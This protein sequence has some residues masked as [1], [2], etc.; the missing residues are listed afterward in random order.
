VLD[1]CAAPGGKTMQLAAAGAHVTAL[2]Q[3]QSR[4][5]RVAENLRRTRHSAELVVADAL[6]WRP[7]QRFD[8]VLLDAPCSATGTLRRHPDAAHL[9]SR[10]DI[11]SM[12]AVQTRLLD[13][14]AAAVSPG[15]VLVYCTCSLEPEEGSFQA[16][17]FSARHG[18]AFAAL[19]FRA[20]EAG[21]VPEWLDGSGH[22]R[23]LPSHL[24][25]L[26]E[27]MKGMDGF[28]AARWRRIGVTS[29]V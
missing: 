24:E 18:N 11:E 29:S 27:G 19:P 3:S 9:K 20:G 5:D 13:A 17:A 23:T 14:A 15:G 4:L 21:L 7:A 1:L 28:F 22:L 2:D 8:A 6:T 25:S 10:A 16:R 12:A 26:P